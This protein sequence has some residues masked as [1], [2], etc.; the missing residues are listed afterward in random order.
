VEVA[1]ANIGPLLATTG[2]AEA[3]AAVVLLLHPLAAVMGVP[4]ALMVGKAAAA[5]FVTMVAA[6]DTTALVLQM[7]R[8]QERGGGLSER[9]S[10]CIVRFSIWQHLVAQLLS[11]S[12]RSLMAEA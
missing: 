7:M 9:A 11:K 12:R 6:V 8:A 2:Q 1:V 5:V 10:I 4:P 3:T